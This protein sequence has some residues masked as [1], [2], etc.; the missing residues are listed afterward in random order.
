[1]PGLGGPGILG[2]ILDSTGQRIQ[3]RVQQ[4]NELDRQSRDAQAKI[5]LDALHAIDEN[6]NPKLTGPAA[7]EVAGKYQSL[8]K[9]N[10]GIKDIV[11]KM[12]DLRGKLFGSKAPAP[13]IQSAQAQTL[14]ASNGGPG[15][16]L[17]S[18]PEPQMQ[19]QQDPN[20]RLTTV[21]NGG[22][23]PPPARS[24]VTVAPD[25][26]GL[27]QPPAKTSL[28]AIIQ[29]GASNQVKTGIA[30]EGRDEAVDFR[31]MA[32]Q[33]KDAME[34]EGLRGDNALA[35]VQATAASHGDKKIAQYTGDDGKL[36]LI[37]QA[38]DGTKYES[39][40]E[41]SVR[42]YVSRLSPGSKL[43][44]FDAKSLS[45]NLGQ[46]FL[47]ESGKPLDVTKLDDADQLVPLTGGMPNRY[48]ISTQNQTT[49]TFD[50][51]VS[52]VPTLNQS[53][54]E[55]Y[56]PLGQAQVAREG[57]SEQIA[58]D[59]E[60]N[61]VAVPLRQSSSPITPTTQAKPPTATPTTTGA[62]T[63]PA[64]TTPAATG[65][66][67]RPISGALPPTERNNQLII[68]RPVRAAAVQLFGDPNTPGVESLES[69]AKLA[70]DPAARMRIG[71][72]A[73][74]I[75]GDLS[76]ADNGGGVG[77][78]VFGNA[79]SVG[80]G[81]LWQS[82]K[83]TTGLT[84]WVASSRVQA[85]QQAVDALKPEEA[86]ALNQMIAA[87]GTV[88][89]LRSLTKGG[90]YKFSVDSM[91]RELP[92]PGVSDVNSSVTY[93]NKLAKIANEVVEGTKGISDMVLPEKESYKVAADRLNAL[94]QG[95]LPAP[96]QRGGAPRGNAPSSV[97]VRVQQN[98]TT[99]EYRHSLDG[100]KTW[101]PGKQ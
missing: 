12:M 78:N 11:G 43:S 16:P 81:D 44:V 90:A 100:G 35:R 56:T 96:P 41:G 33:H 75:I 92:I 83:N 51:T 48:K 50:N 26:G 5:Y 58:I 8:Y 2:S 45:S 31:K 61:A 84:K 6:G 73:R 10:P 82:L 32:Q 40:S 85:T 52:A 25:A 3:E 70:D 14:D 69:F 97:P 72:A 93:Y 23:T 57:T 88:V 37:F 36:H 66:G 59:G 94:G 74:L 18:A 95:R 53:R 71:T 13:M 4:S 47:D 39:D 76:A 77:A 98:P 62:P 55:S 64:R 49:K 79:V 7:E 86:R 60:G 99:G 67:N 34:L 91:E 27:A 80:G 15:G 54:P 19:N 29:A 46:Q 28:A 21:S 68:A 87:Y 24:A 89:G 22:L 17:V 38:P 42:P 65:G 20:N 9:H 1:M 30:K 101:L 63:G